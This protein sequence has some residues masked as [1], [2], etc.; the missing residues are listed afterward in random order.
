MLERR[1]L[2]FLTCGRLPVAF[3]LLL[4]LPVCMWEWLNHSTKHQYGTISHIIKTTQKRIKVVSAIMEWSMMMCNCVLTNLCKE[5]LC[6]LPWEIYFV[7]LNKHTL[8]GLRWMVT[9]M[10][11]IRRIAHDLRLNFA[12]GATMA[13][14]CI[15]ACGRFM[16]VRTFLSTAAQPPLHTDEHN[17]K[18][19][20]DC[21]Q[22]CHQECNTPELLH[23]EPESSGRQT[24]T[25]TFSCSYTCSCPDQNTLLNSLTLILTG[26]IMNS[27]R[28]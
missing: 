24:P 3:I 8:T 2:S 17:Q 5:L 18:Q 27:G 6:F 16:A 15:T 11:M 4:I 12:T 10:C 1:S 13:T 9:D 28:L 26:S 21:G 19:R 23:S 14:V 25:N 22:A 20:K 7:C